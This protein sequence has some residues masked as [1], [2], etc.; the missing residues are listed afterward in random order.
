MVIFASC[1]PLID[2]LSF[3]EGGSFEIGHPKSRAWK[4]FGRKW[5]EDGGLENLTIFMDVICVSSL[6]IKLNNFYQTK[7]I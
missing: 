7:F 1:F 4:N 5:T 6:T 2:W 3:G